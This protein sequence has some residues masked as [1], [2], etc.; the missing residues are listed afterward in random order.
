MSRHELSL[1]FHDRSDAGRALG[2]EL[3]KRR[4]WNDP[5]VLALPR[6]GVPVAYEV[7]LLLDAPLDLLVVRKIGHPQHEEY[8]IGAIA[9]GGVTVMNA[10]TDG[11]LGGVRQEE[12][13]R[14]VAR[15]QAELARREAAYREDRPMCEVARHEVILVDDGLATGATMRAAVQAA[16]QLGAA[17]VTVAVP[18]GA[19]ET[20]E[21]L[22]AVADD[23]VCVRTPE[24]FHA[25]GLWYAQFP[26]TSDEEVR[27]LMFQAR[28]HIVM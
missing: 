6:G 4:D 9:S 23:V 8:A 7:A 18:V 17:H 24:P 19:F 28:R 3:L 2:E 25:V 12:V 20:C 22:R 5:L 27:E 26:Q 13:A 16:R 14:I 1:G 15:E 10:D 21:A 11:F